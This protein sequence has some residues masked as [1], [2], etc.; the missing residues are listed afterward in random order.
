[1]GAKHTGA[2]VCSTNA[3]SAYLT[4]SICCSASDERPLAV[5]LDDVRVLHLMSARLPRARVHAH[6]ARVCMRTMEFYKEQRL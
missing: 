5:S 4:L 2:F 6:H 3:D 1:V